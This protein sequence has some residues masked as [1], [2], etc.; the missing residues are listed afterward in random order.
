M[1]A[2]K[3]WMTLKTVLTNPTYF[4]LCF[5]LTLNVNSKPL[6]CFFPFIHFFPP[7]IAWHAGSV[8]C[9]TPATSIGRFQPFLFV[10]YSMYSTFTWLRFISEMVDNAVGTGRSEGLFGLRVNVEVLKCTHVLKKKTVLMWLEQPLQDMR[11]QVRVCFLM[12]CIL[13]LFRV[14]TV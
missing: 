6:T 8:L 7:T 5:N 10:F 14:Y 9:M 1:S 2:L 12:I 3:M 11:P 13:F 4:W